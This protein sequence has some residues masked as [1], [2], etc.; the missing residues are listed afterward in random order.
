MCGAHFL[1]HDCLPGGVTI[2]HGQ[3]GLFLLSG[4]VPALPVAI[5]WLANHDDLSLSSSRPTYFD[6][7]HVLPPPAVPVYQHTAKVFCFLNKIYKDAPPPQIL[8]GQQLQ[9]NIFF[10]A[11]EIGA[12]SLRR[13][14][15]RCQLQ[16]NLM[17]GGYGNPAPA[18]TPSTK[19]FNRQS[20]ELENCKGWLG[21]D[22]IELCRKR[23]LNLAH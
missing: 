21:A 17:R 20:C 22:S 11:A 18:F 3:A 5:P 4:A 10:W 9:S 2:A 16:P 15:P 12:C 6:P 7:C 23:A 19:I 1:Q 13:C 14:I 8:A